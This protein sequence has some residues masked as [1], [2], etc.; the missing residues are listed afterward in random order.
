MA[1]PPKVTSVRIPST[2]MQKGVKSTIAVTDQA[3]AAGKKSLVASKQKLQ[4]ALQSGTKAEIRAATSAVLRNQKTLTKAVV[5]R[6]NLKA[7]E[8]LANSLCQ[9]NVLF[10]D[11][12]F[13]VPK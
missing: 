4:T 11:Y 9:L 5:L 6:E 13:L 7:S 3:I 10:G 1:M 2:P 8:K 12:K